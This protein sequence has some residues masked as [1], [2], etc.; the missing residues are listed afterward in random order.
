MSDAHQY[1]TFLLDGEEYAVDILRVQEIKGYSA[2]TP[3]PN[4][5]PYLRGVMNLRGNVVPVIDLRLRLGMPAADHGKFTV[6]VL[7]TVGTRVRGMIVD[8]VSDV[9]QLAPSAIEPTP[10]LGPAV[11]TSF[12]HGMAKPHGRLLILLDVDR[13][14]GADGVPVPPDRAAA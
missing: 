11:D 3:I 8:A 7:L 9:L 1:L 2:I 6:I 13:V 5:P 12:I 10:G 14:V 4:T